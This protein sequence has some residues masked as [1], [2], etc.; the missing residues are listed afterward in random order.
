MLLGDG[1]LILNDNARPHLGKTVTYLLSKYEWEVLSH[2][3]YSPDMSPPDLIIPQVKRAYAW[4]PFSLSGRGFCSGYPSHP[5]IEQQWDPKW[6]SKSSE[7][8]GR[9]H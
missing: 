3:P 5:R 9:S 1:T 6:Y 7:T 8:L 4:T 2:A